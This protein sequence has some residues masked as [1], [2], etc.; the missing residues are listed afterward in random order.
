M[1]YDIKEGTD[2]WSEHPEKLPIE[3]AQW[4]PAENY[5]IVGYHDG[6]IKLFEADKGTE[7]VV[8]ERQ[9]AGTFI[10]AQI[11]GVRGICI[12]ESYLCVE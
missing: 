3:D 5:L 10:P 8:F 1:F 9:G 4:N 2:V 11:I 7:S 12:P 6:V